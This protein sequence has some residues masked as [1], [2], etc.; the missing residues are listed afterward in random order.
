MNNLMIKSENQKNIIRRF[1]SLLI[2]LSLLFKNILIVIF[3]SIYFRRKY[4]Q[5]LNDIIVTQLCSLAIHCERVF[6]FSEFE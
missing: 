3:L 4:V 1:M 2:G 5:P 6:K